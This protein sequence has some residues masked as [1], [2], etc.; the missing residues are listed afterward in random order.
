[1]RHYIQNCFCVICFLWILGK[2]FEHRHTF[3]GSIRH[4]LRPWKPPPFL[5]RSPKSYKS[6]LFGLLHKQ[7]KRLP[8]AKSEPDWAQ[9]GM[10]VYIH[11]YIHI[12]LSIYMSIYTYPYIYIYIYTYIYICIYIYIYTIFVNATPASDRSADD[13]DLAW[14]SGLTNRSNVSPLICFEDVSTFKLH[15]LWRV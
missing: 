2:D 3:V 13:P 11:V 10:P 14:L 7:K 9:K 12:Y 4:W 8:W 5:R 6:Y 1:M 15:R